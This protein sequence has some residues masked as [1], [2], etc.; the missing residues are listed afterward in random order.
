ML[1]AQIQQFS[2]TLSALRDF[3]GVV[4][5]LLT[6]AHH[7]QIERD[8]TVLLPLIIALSRKRGEDI[9]ESLKE[10]ALEE[11]DSGINI[12]IEGD[13]GVNSSFLI[14]YEGERAYDFE[15][16][17][18]GVKRSFDQRSLLYKSALISLISAA[19]W[20]LS[21]LL[22]SYLDRCPDGL[23]IKNKLIS[24]ADLQEIGSIEEAREIL[25][26]SI[27]ADVIRGSFED[28]EK[29]LKSNINLNMGY[30]DAER[31]E[32]IEAYQRRNVLIH[33]NGM[34][35]GIY[36]SKVRPQARLGLKVGD[37][38]FVSREYLEAAISRFERSFVLISLELWKKLESDNEERSELIINLVY[39]HLL[40]DRYDI[41]KGF[42][43]FICGDKQLP[44]RDRLISQV[45]YWQ[46]M[47]WS[48]EFHE[49]Q[50][51]VQCF[52]I[53][54]KDEL[55]HLA[56]HA[57]LDEEEEFFVLLPRVLGSGGVTIN[58]VREWPLFRGMRQSSLYDERYADDD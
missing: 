21:R 43:Q 31:D 46:A 36:I 3:V 2:D 55:F 12:E 9:P 48:G 52:D 44:E 29:Y 17:M 24:L 42:S 58:D 51:A 14:K 54:A 6:G 11:L 56:K 8:T 40:A 10:K 47:K 23:G 4:D 19:E 39:Q 34:V 38:L 18:K 41:A 15:V 1:A 22:H 28:W 5:P 50:G 37:E 33:N 57:L 16:A 32:L 20:F 13:G 27:V 35:N 49:V 26:E 25:V 53:S 30:L 45:N 7:Q